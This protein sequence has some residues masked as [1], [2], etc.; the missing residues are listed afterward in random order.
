MPLMHHRE[1]NHGDE[2][3]RKGVGQATRS[4]RC[5]LGRHP[6][7]L[8]RFAGQFTQPNFELSPRDRRVWY[9]RLDGSVMKMIDFLKKHL[10]FP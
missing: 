10:D 7:R 5:N 4:R 2:Q 6:I 1:C 9:L 3:S 8:T